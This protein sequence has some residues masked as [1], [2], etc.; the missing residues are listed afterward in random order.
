MNVDQACRM[1]PEY[2]LTS[3]Y[4]ALLVTQLGAVFTLSQLFERVEADVLQ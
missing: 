4:S 1:F 2:H 3:D